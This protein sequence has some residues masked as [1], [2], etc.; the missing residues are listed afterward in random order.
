MNE[1]QKLKFQK[2]KNSKQNIEIFFNYLKRHKSP[3]SSILLNALKQNIPEE[4]FRQ[5]IKD[6]VLVYIEKVSSRSK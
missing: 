1:T 4:E 3:Y 6:D 2:S 5:K